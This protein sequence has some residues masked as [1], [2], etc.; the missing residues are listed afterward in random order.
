MALVLSTLFCLAAA[1]TARHQLARSQARHQAALIREATLQAEREALA[2]QI[3][4][5]WETLALTEQ[6]V[7]ALS[8]EAAAM[9]EI[10][11]WDVDLMEITH[12]APLA[13]DAVEGMDYAGDPRVTSSG[14]ETQIG[15]TVAA[16]PE[17]PFGTQ[18]YIPGYGLRIVQ[19]RGGSITE[20]R[21]DIAV[22]SRQEANQ[23]GRIFRE[24]YLEPTP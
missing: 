20:G 13:P 17:V 21:L 7:A 3:Q 11:S 18:V 5:A 22:A 14:E 6:Q 16:G 10:L 2:V 12:Y 1:T 19:D 24:V 23:L 4:E 9:A 15:V 8:Q